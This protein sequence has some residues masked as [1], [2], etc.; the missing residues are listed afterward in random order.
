MPTTALTDLPPE[1]LDHITTYL[2][3]ANSLANLSRT[4][5][6]LHTFVETNAWRTFADQR[7]PSL[8]PHSSRSWKL[9]ARSLTSLSRA[10]D[11]R[12]F[13]ARYIEPH[14]DITSFP[15]RK[16]VERWKRPRGQTI[17]F[18]P[19]LDVYEQ[20]LTRGGKR[21]VL[22]Y[23]AGAEVCV[24]IREWR[25]GRLGKEGE[26]V[27][28]RTYR[29][30]SAYEGRDD[31]TTVHLLRPKGE[32]LDVRVVTGTANGDLQVLRLLEG[33]GEDVEKAYLTTQG[34]AVRSSSLL[35]QEGR[36]GLLAAEVGDSKICLYPLQDGQ[37]KIAPSSQIDIKSAALEN[38]NVLSKAY[39]PW[40]TNF[41]SESHLAVGLGPSE[42]PIHIYT[43]TPSG[44]SNEHVRKF[45]LASDTDFDD[46]SD[47]IA[48]GGV[49]R[50]PLS[51]V[52]PIAPLPPS[53]ATST[54]DSQT[55][56]SG[57]YDGIV[58]LHDLRSPRD[59]EATY[60]DPTDDSAIYSLLPH[61]RES[62]LVGSNRHNLLKVFDLRLGAKCYSYLAAQPS[63]A[64]PP[65]SSDWSLFLKP[66]AS[67]S[68]SAHSN[69]HSQPWGQ[70]PRRAPE[71]SVYTL[72]SASPTSPHV[73]AGIENN[74]VEMAFADVRDGHPDPSYFRPWRGAGKKG[75]GGD[76][77][78]W[79]GWRAREVIDLAC[80]EQRADV[81]LCVQRGL[82]DGVGEGQG[83]G[84]EGLDW[85][86]RRGGS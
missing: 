40:S 20:D 34:Q 49:A 79:N 16:K 56:L 67:S 42:E 75:K 78:D 71:S 11:R 65:P 66:H 45:T 37:H 19:H 5:K 77:A 74:V 36:P 27:R 82:G 59:V 12:A 46:R 48:P 15:G 38:G 68:F 17:G 61:G 21:E 62:L 51:S 60:T 81:R 33:E 43:V 54:H 76:C 25:V 47:E 29:P 83:E 80:V 39:R 26:K 55:F 58:R 14:G 85:R 18:T 4:S 35:Q 44:L 9:T 50:K 63:A 53:S 84:V 70:R 8:C 24:R 31:I 69:S 52:Y 32:E 23:S 72:A 10:W 41:L 7:F 28:W 64:A 13:V 3:T 6:T 2:P 1:L 22:A 86:W 30:L 57:A 73:F